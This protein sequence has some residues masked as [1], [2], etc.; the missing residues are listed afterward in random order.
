MSAIRKLQL[1][2][3]IVLLLLPL[4]AVSYATLVLPE[5]KTVVLRNPLLCGKGTVQS[6]YRI[7]GLLAGR[8]DAFYWPLEQIDRNV[9]PELWQKTAKR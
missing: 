1:I 6:H 5:G 7:E 9:R 3:A 4:Y 8:A 2:V